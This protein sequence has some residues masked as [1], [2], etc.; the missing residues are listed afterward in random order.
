[1]RRWNGWGDDTVSYP[2][3][4]LALALLQREIGFATPPRDVTFAEVV[5]QVPASR[6]PVHPLIVSPASARVLHARGQS[7]PDLIA[8]RSG[9]SL[10]FADGIAYPTHAD[11]VRT[12]IRYA[13]DVGAALIPYGGGTSVVGHVNVLPSPIPTLTVDLSRMSRLLALDETSDLATFGAG[14]SGADLEAQLRARGYTLGHFPQ[15]FEYS[16]LGGWIATRSKGQQSVYYGGIEHLFAGGRLE[17]PLGTVELAPLPASA[18]GL[19]VR[20]TV[21]GSEGR[22]GV[23]TEATIRI[24]RLPASEEFRAVF[25]ASFEQGMAAV[26]QIAQAR[27][28]FSMLRLLNDVETELTLSLGSHLRTRDLL[29][30]LLRLRGIGAGKSMLML[31]VTGSPSAV[32]STVRQMLDITRHHGGVE[33]M[34]RALGSQ[35]RRSRF[36]TPYLRNTLWEL[37]YA[38][39]TVET[40]VDWTHVPAA[41]NAI[42]SALRQGLTDRGERVHVLTHLS[43]IYPTGSSIYTTYIY[44]IAAD[45][46]E[47]LERW[48]ILKDAASQSILAHGATISHQHGVGVDHLPYMLKEKGEDGMALIRDLCGHFDPKGMMNPGKL[49]H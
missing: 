36:R 44:R 43:H 33:I 14:I 42:Q 40:A 27:L 10:T 26:R 6:L 7:L 34:G 32:R 37:G 46:E 24:S 41:L 19:D 3:Q 48:K 5:G 39:D 22:M 2:L 30:G 18:T 31:G 1:M 45:P 11:E 8:M 17:T 13:A 21:L 28:P 29:E 49:F 38:V 25:F 23:I 4:P 9:S 16:T 20:E 12:L 47:T 15:S 35:W